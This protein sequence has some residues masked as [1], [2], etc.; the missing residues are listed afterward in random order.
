VTAQASPADFDIPQLGPSLGR[1][2]APPPPPAGAPQPHWIALDDIR[3]GLVTELIETAGQAREWARQGDRDLALAT[4]GKE[5]WSGAWSRATGLVTDRARQAINRRLEGAADEARL[6]RRKRRALAL[7]PEE[8]HYLSARLRRDDAA[9]HD[10]LEVLER[11]IHQVRG[12]PG[13]RSA[14][15]TYQEALQTAARRLEAAWLALEDQLQREWASW[16]RQ[17]QVVRGWRRP[18]WPLWVSGAILLGVALW[19]G[20]MLGGYVTVPG[21]LRGLAESFWF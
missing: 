11:S 16:E 5:I 3:L 6:P 7:D 20:L 8:T 10:A 18:G 13:S 21:P 12:S 2:V 14:S 17:V 4:I 19:A 1:L 9:F 15:V